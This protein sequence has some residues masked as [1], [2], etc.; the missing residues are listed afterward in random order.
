MCNKFE[1]PSKRRKNFIDLVAFFGGSEKNNL[2][3]NNS[4][5]FVNTTKQTRLRS[6]TL[7]RTFPRAENV[8]SSEIQ[9]ERQSFQSLTQ[10]FE[11]WSDQ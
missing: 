6:H 3:A 11:H 1:S 7:T 5:L 4:T 2:H 10:N 8:D 9:V